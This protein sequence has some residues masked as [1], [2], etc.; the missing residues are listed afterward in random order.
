MKR[1]ALLLLLLAGVACSDRALVANATAAH[2]YAEAHYE[3]ACV[4]QVGPPECKQDQA[5]LNDAKREV[6][7]DN[8]VY[9]IGKLPKVARQRLRKIANEVPK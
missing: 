3:W 2:T 6:E 1:A 7:L 5:V 4:D 8:R 9:K